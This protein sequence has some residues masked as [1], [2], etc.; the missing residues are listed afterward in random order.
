MA[1]RDLAGISLTVATGSALTNMRRPSELVTDAICALTGCGSPSKP[2]KT[3][4]NSIAACTAIFAGFERTRLGEGIGIRIRLSLW[5]SALKQR[6]Q[7]VSKKPSPLAS[8]AKCISCGATLPALGAII[9]G[10]PADQGHF[11][12]Q[13]LE[14]MCLFRQPRPD[15]V[16]PH[17]NH[18][19]VLQA[20]VSTCQHGL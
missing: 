6:P 13:F 19:P 1:V 14:P 20:L 12:R 15:R 2:A 17:R 11:A 18:R 10:V 5:A 16:C 3:T 4:E 7:R 8:G 9:A